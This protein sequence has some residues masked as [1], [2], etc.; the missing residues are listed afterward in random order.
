MYRQ[1]KV[2]NGVWHFKSTPKGDWKERSKTSLSQE[3]S[4]LQAEL[5]REKENS[6]V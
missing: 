6:Y 3:I 1:D 4:A 5:K 2:I